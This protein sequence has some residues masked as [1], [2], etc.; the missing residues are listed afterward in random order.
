LRDTERGSS[1][2]WYSYSIPLT[3]SPTGSAFVP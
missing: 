3:V 2:R 1:M